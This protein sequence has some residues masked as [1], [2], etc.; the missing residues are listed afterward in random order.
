MK[1]AFHI[2]LFAVLSLPAPVLADSIWGEFDV[3]ADDAIPENGEK[4]IFAGRLNLGYLATSG[5]TETASFNGKLAL[6]WDLEKWRHAVVMSSIRSEEDGITT[7]E[8]H[9]AGYK[10]DRK[11][12]E[13]N[14]LFFLASWEQDEFSGFD[15]QTSQAVGYGRRM[16]ETDTQLLDL[17]IGVGA[18][19]TE[20]SDGTERDET[21][22]RLA[23]N[24]KWQFSETSDFTQKLAVESGDENTYTESVTGLSL[25]VMGNLDL[26]ISYTIKR[27]SDVPLGNENTDTY[28]TVSLQYDF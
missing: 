5:N 20:L 23:G 26:A 13:K 25:Q 28:T 6:G 9:Q 14:Y 16:L 17:E 19:Q 8:N 11:L 21:I 10:L 22:G 4:E 24:Y 18:R 1:S 27:N 3:V 12:D 7:A 15:E 2:F